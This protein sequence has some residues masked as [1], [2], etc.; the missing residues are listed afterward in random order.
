MR[1]TLAQLRKMKFPY[2]EENEY[3]FSEELNGFEDIVSS[4]KAKVFEKIRNIG[5]DSFEVVLDIDVSL[6]VQCSVTLEEIPYQI[7]TIKTVYYTFDKEIV[8]SDDYI[9]IDGQTLDT[10]EEILSEILIEKPMKFVK[11]GVEYDS[12]EEEDSDEEYINPAFAGL[13]DLLK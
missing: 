1:Y 11:D 3:D 10:R 6:I 2:T 9:I 4:N 8:S 12:E 7:K 5:S 13:K